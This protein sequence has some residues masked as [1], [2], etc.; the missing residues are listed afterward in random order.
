[1][2]GHCRQFQ[3]LYGPKALSPT[4]A[5]S[6]SSGHSQGADPQHS[7]RIDTPSDLISMAQ[8]KAGDKRK[9][10]GKDKLRRRYRPV[11]FCVCLTALQDL[12]VLFLKDGTPV[13]GQQKFMEGPGI[14]VTCVRNKEKSTVGELCD[15]F[16]SVSWV[17]PRTFVKASQTTLSAVER[18]VA[19]ISGWRYLKTRR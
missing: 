11:R 18:S 17:Q 4:G 15:L 10:E 19:A 13:W 12:T 2:H 5:L 1:M 3:L 9:S 8:N 14:W 6:P 16:D 7:P